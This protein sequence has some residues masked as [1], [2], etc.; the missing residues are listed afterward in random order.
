MINNG[1]NSNIN[2]AQF[3]TQNNYN[4]KCEFDGNEFKTFE[5]NLTTHTMNNMTP[6]ARDKYKLIK[7][8]KLSFNKLKEPIKTS[9]DFYRIGKMLGKGAFGRVNLAIHK[10]CNQLVA[11]KSINKQFLSEDENSKKKMM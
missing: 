4:N 2:N 10:L 11:V 5:S 7:Q 3:N 1:Q 6:R 9:A 8:I